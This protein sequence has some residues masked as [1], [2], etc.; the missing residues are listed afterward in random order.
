[1]S[2]VQ[3]VTATAEGAEG[4]EKSVSRSYAS[5]WLDAI[6]GA[7]ERLPGPTWAAYL[8][9]TGL[10]L[11]YVAVEAALSSRGLFGQDPAYFA[12]AFGMIYPLV[13]YHYLSR[14]ALVAWDT[15]RPSTDCD[16]G[17]AAGW[18]TQ[19]STTPARAAI[20][21]YVAAVVFYIA[22]LAWSPQGFDLVGH[23][24]AFVAMRVV[25]EAFWLAPLT[26][27]VVYMIY[28]QTRIVSQLHRS[29]VRV[30]LLQPGPLHA[31]SRLTAR[32]AIAL[33]LIQ[34]FL[35]LVP[36]PNVSESARLALALVVAPFTLLSVAAFVLPL[37]G[38]YSLLEAEKG[39]RTAIVSTR[40][41]S[42]LAK[43]HDV[44]DEETAGSPDADASRLAQVRIDGLNKAL[45]SLL[46]ERDFV[47][48]LSSWPWD[49]S[50]LRAVVSAFALPIVLFI[51]TRALER[52]V[53]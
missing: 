40:L 39:R 49:P 36:L 30:D 5:S 28:R 35:I 24:P 25:S 12:Y 13:A 45:T 8:V 10:A 21:V 50:T 51:L 46:Q 4:G 53:L 22:L 14:G 42:T 18:R 17:Q 33:L 52:F 16:D 27:M 44:V 43:L 7:I 20:V 37:R 19:L 34:I 31:M 3:P 23:P 15:F 1:M 6:V 29:V 2:L 32:N 48:H 11:S 9:L 47:G 38:M 26:W 41:D